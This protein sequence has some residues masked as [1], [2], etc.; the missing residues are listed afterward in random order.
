MKNEK[1]ET[2]IK[3]NKQLKLEINVS[4]PNMITPKFN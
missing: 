3:T 1:L 4:K 2:T